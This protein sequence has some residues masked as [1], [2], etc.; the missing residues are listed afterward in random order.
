MV[1]PALYLSGD[2]QLHVGLRTVGNV[3]Y[4]ILETHLGETDRVEGNLQMSEAVASRFQCTIRDTPN[5]TITVDVEVSPGWTI[6]AELEIREKEIGLRR[7]EIEVKN[8]AEFFPY[9]RP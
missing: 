2:G 1:L 4:T 6:P 8:A 7:V 3:R 5:Q 9:L